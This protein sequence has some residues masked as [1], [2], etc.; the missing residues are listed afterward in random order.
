ML[1]KDDKYPTLFL[2]AD[3]GTNAARK[4][5]NV[6]P[7]IVTSTGAE[8]KRIRGPWN[9]TMLKTSKVYEGLGNLNDI[10]ADFNTRVEEGRSETGV[11]EAI[12]TE[13]FKWSLESAGAFLFETRL[14]CLSKEGN[15]RADE[16]I[17][18]ARNVFLLSEKLF[19]ND[20][21]WVSK[22]IARNV[23]DD[24]CNGWKT[25]AKHS[26]V[27]VNEKMA[28]ISTDLEEG[29]EPSGF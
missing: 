5:Y 25:I 1:K 28:S 17:E 9:H 11:I 15:P 18:A 12:R 4:R 27:L 19:M 14:G 21:I 10:A 3:Q 20:P 7:G 8:W 29:V 6:P 16:L 2:T 23:Y 24:F 26:A 22:L 13:L